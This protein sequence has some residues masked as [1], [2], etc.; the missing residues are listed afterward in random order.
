MGGSYYARMTGVVS[1][2]NNASKSAIK[3]TSFSE[4]KNA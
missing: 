1:E 4:N 3:S 2:N